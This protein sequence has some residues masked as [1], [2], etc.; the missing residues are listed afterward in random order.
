MKISFVAPS[1]RPHLWANLYN[2]LQNN[3]LAWEVIFVGPTPPISELPKNVRWIKTNVKP[4]QCT[5]IGFMEAQGEYISLTADDAIY[6]TPNHKGAADNMI[7]FIDS[8]IP[9]LPENGKN[10]MF[11]FR[12]FEDSYCVESSQTHYLVQNTTGITSPLLF[13]FFVTLKETYLKMNGY[14]NRFVCGQAENDFQLRVAQRIGSS[15]NTLC[16]LAMVWANHDEGHANVSKFREYHAKETEILKR[17]WLDDNGRYQ[18]S[19]REGHQPYVNDGSLLL[20][21]QGDKGEWI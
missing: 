7:A 12:M 10:Y 16:P 18:I 4:S 14:D 6:F 17:C 5:H 15:A 1:I 3:K 20:S 19:S 8:S 11:G 13:P 2:S 9:S 21:S